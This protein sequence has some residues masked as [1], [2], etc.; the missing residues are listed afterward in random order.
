MRGDVDEVRMTMMVFWG[1]L[2]PFVVFG[3]EVGGSSLFCLFTP[4][5]GRRQVFGRGVFRK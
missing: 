2:S 5:S 3:R 1:G 4:S